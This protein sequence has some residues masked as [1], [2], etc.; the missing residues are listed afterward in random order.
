MGMNETD[1]RRE[2]MC[3]CDGQVETQANKH[4]LPNDEEE[5]DRLDLVFS[6]FLLFKDIY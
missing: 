2:N 4:S 3:M 1:M 6:F 5:K